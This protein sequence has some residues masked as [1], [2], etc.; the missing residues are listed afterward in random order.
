MRPATW[1]LLAALAL[2]VSASATFATTLRHLDTRSLTLGSS[3]I[4]VGAVESTTPRWSADR[5]KIFTDIDIRVAE[6][7]KGAGG[8]SGE[9]LTL[10]QLGGEIDGVRYSIPG[11]PLFRRGEEA[12]VFVWRDA[13]GQ[14]QVNGLAQGKFDITRDATGA[15]MVQRSAPGF[16]VKD[17]RRL[18]ALKSGE[19][20]PRITLD[21]LKLEIRRVL[22]TPEAGR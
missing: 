12:L 22:A 5:K 14:A 11:G 10:T 15:A 6:S 9:R 20:T 16:A 18:N 4:V 13:K 7:L 21:E 19:A 2:I 3:D 17:V 1:L 8:G